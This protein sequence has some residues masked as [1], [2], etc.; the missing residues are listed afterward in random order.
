[1]AHSL[2]KITLYNTA[3]SYHKPPSKVGRNDPCPC[4]SRKKFKNCCID[5]PSHDSVHLHRAHIEALRKFRDH[6]FKETARTQQFGYV[7][8]E[9]AIDFKGYKLVAVGSQ[10]HYSKKWKFFPDFLLDYVPSIFGKEWGE[11]EL[12]KPVEERH[13]VVQLRSKCIEALRNLQDKQTKHPDGYYEAELTGYPLA[14]FGF[15]YDL[16]IVH[17]N[18]RLDEQILSRLKSKDQ[19]QGAR[20]ELFAEATCHRAGYEIVPEDEKDRS[21]RHAE[22]VATHKRTGQRISVE[23]KSKHQEGVLGRPTGKADQ[24]K[25]NLRFGKLINDAIAKNPSHPLVIFL[26][27]NLPPKIAR[28][29]FPQK[30]GKDFK[31]PRAI[32]RVLDEARRKAGGKDP[33]AMVVVTNHPDHYEIE[34]DALPRKNTLSLISQLTTYPVTYPDALWAIHDAAD[35]YGNIPKDLPRDG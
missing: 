13:P 32:M 3:M 35:L 2:A 34:D 26:D 28:T 25:S 6:E 17:H 18:R 27:T 23:A 31:P 16:Y 22:F 5:A 9:I 20:H 15:A 10:M 8:P 19:F 4:G 24:L 30:G 11:T 29:V 1:M 7:K 21:T 14:Y 33:F 12:K